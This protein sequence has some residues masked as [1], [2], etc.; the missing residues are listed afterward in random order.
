MLVIIIG[1]QTFKPQLDYFAERRD[2]LFERYDN[3]LLESGHFLNQKIDKNNK[4]GNWLYSLCLKDKKVSRD[5]LM[6]FLKTRGIETRPLF[7]P[8]NMMPAFKKISKF[9]KCPNSISLPSSAHLSKTEIDYISDNL[10]SYF[11]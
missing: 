7:Y 8:M 3:N 5:K 1:L 11:K 2:Q 9:S 6:K 4:S 10:L